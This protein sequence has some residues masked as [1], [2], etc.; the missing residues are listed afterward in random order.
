MRPSTLVFR[1]QP[2]AAGR[3]TFAPEQNDSTDS[4]GTEWEQSALEQLHHTTRTLGGK[5]EKHL[6]SRNSFHATLK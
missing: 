2:A 5:K 6:V 4:E 3:L 1:Q